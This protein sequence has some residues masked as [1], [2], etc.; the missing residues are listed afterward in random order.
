MCYGQRRS[1]QFPQDSPNLLKQGPCCCRC[2]VTQPC[3]ALCNPTDCSALGS[4]VLHC[5][6]ELAQ[7]HIHRVGDAIQPSHPLSSPSPPALNLSQ[8]QGLFQRV[9]SLHWGANVFPIKTSLSG[10]WGH[11]GHPHRL[12]RHHGLSLMPWVRIPPVARAVWSVVWMTWE[13]DHLVPS[14]VHH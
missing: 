9:G 14:T 5:L 7:T 11:A 3:L 2:S 12:A 13:G 4:P 6:P 10:F 1:H 8:H